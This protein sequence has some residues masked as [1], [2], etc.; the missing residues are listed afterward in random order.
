MRIDVRRDAGQARFWNSWEWA[1]LACTMS[2]VDALK[3]GLHVVSVRMLAGTGVMTVV[4]LGDT[5]KVR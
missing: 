4:S 3:R 1:S 5:T 2:R